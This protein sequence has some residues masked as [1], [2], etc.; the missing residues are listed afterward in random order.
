MKT[1]EE[2]IRDS[3]TATPEQIRENIE[4]SKRRNEAQK[5]ADVLMKS[6]KPAKVSPVHPY[7]H[8][9]G[10]LVGFIIKTRKDKYKPIL[11]RVSTF[12]DDDDANL[13][14]IGEREPQETLEAAQ[15]LFKTIGDFEYIYCP[16]P[17]KSGGI[18]GT[19]LSEIIKANPEN[20]S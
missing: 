8:L 17:V 1:V 3:R 19:W 6:T 7:A 14:M 18:F 13:V 2:H 12:F 16:N 11:G 20:N 9:D 5:R 4:K 10:K 15:E